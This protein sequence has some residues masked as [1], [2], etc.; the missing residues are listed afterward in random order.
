VYSPVVDLSES[1]APLNRFPYD[2]V[3]TP[4]T[5]SWPTTMSTG[6]ESGAQFHWNVTW[7]AV[8]L[9]EGVPLPE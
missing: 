8:H 4:S 9:P 1:D 5:Y 3:R 7:T 2:S 6:V